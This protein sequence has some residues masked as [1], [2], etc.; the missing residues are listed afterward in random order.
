MSNESTAKTIELILA[1]I[2][3]AERVVFDLGGKLVEICTRDLTDPAE[4]RSA[5][6]AAREEGFPELKFIS[7]E[8]G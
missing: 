1:L 6:E 3:V 5:I 8:K 2:P 4:V 7:G